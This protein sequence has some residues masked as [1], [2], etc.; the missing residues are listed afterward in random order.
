M[1]PP[2][3]IEPTNDVPLPSDISADVA[4]TRAEHL[5]VTANTTALL[6]ELGMP[7][8]FSG[9]DEATA[10]AIIA[11][12]PR[13]SPIPTRL[14]RGVATKLTALINEYDQ[15][16]IKDAVQIRTYVTHKLLE[17]SDCGE[18][19]YE[20]KA[21]ELLGKVTDVGLFTERSE[22]TVHHKSSQD[23]EE[24]IKDRIKRLLNT[25]VVDV[26][27]IEDDLDALLGTPT[28]PAGEETP[29][30]E[31]PPGELD[32]D[33]ELGVIPEEERVRLEDEIDAHLKHTAD[34]S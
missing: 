21:L 29:A 9:E 20:L 7:L 27:P 10:R 22:V 32:L 13:S 30:T 19:K 17:I 31:A 2:V 3:Y 18:P 5:E 25:D 11:N 28:E 26:V 34:K 16:V 4:Q 6:A 8:E 1:Q 23:L 33:S 14:T 12:A 15:Q 24:A